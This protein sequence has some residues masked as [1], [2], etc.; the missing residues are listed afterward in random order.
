MAA[1]LFFLIFYRMIEQ[2]NKAKVEQTADPMKNVNAR[3]DRS[4]GKRKEHVADGKQ[5]VE[6]Q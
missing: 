2:N 6:G 3:C 1:P 5:N 4:P